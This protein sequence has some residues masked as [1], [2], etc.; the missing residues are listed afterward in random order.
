LREQLD[1][2]PVSDLK[3]WCE[4]MLANFDEREGF[5]SEQAEDWANNQYEILCSRLEV[6]HLVFTKD[7]W[8]N[9]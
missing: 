8:W 2:S 7:S 3:S 5:L 9:E 4:F 6:D 1:P